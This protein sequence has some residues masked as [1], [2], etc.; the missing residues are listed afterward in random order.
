M[1]GKCKILSILAVFL[2]AFTASPH[3]A[4]AQ[5]V[6]DCQCNGPNGTCAP[7]GA[8]P[9]GAFQQGLARGLGVA[10]Q[11]YANAYN[12]GSNQVIRINVGNN[13]GLN[14]I[15]GIFKFAMS[16]V[17]N[18]MDAAGSGSPNIAIVDMVVDDIATQVLTQ[19]F[20]TYLT[21]QLTTL[22]AEE[23]NMLCRPM[24]S[25]NISQLPNNIKT[26]MLNPTCN[27]IPALLMSFG[28]PVQQ[29]HT[30]YNLNWGQ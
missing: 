1:L 2:A 7:G 14:N 8:G 3:S 18:I 19:V 30:I 4:F 29:Q 9:M 27:A 26:L 22:F 17:K 13:Y 12:Y 11:D 10:G 21:P 5:A 16:E 20:S 15:Q 25:A 28:V 24:P 6:D 23:Q